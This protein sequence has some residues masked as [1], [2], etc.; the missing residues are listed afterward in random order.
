MAL[1]LGKKRDISSF[2]S[3]TISNW[4]PAQNDQYSKLYF[5]VAYSD[6]TELQALLT[7]VDDV[8]K[9]R[10]CF[11]CVFPYTSVLL[12]KIYFLPIVQQQAPH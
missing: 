2:L 1:L 12:F 8:V 3:V 4:P 7:Q 11:A 9:G 5:R 6:F 10:F